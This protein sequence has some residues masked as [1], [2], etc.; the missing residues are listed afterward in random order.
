VGHAGVEGTHT[1]QPGFAL[2]LRTSAAG[3]QLVGP[4]RDRT[5]SA[6]GRREFRAQQ[7]WKDSSAAAA[8]ARAGSLGDANVRPRASF[9]RVLRQCFEWARGCSTSAVGFRFQLSL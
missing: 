5:A 4:H 7:G 3:W 8:T 9:C 2:A 1:T 6:W